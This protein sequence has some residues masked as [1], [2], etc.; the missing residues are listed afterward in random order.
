MEPPTVRVKVA[1]T[2][3]ACKECKR[4]YTLAELAA[5]TVCETCGND[6]RNGGLS[7]TFERDILQKGLASRP[8]NNYPATGSEDTY[9]SELLSRVQVSKYEIRPCTARRDVPARC[10]HA[11]APM[12]QAS[13]SRVA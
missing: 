11:V 8:R 13:W 12:L 3:V 9:S 7:V 6:L 5:L 4:E 10:D 1:A 2:K